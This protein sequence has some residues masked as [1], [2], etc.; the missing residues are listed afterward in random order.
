[1]VSQEKS[2]QDVVDE[3]SEGVAVM[4]ATIFTH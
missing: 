3:V 2:D 4:I 1:M